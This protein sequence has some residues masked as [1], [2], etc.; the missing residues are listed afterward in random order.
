MRKH[1]V[2]SFNDGLSLEMQAVGAPIHV[3]AILPG[4]VKTRVFIDS[5]VGGDK[6]FRITTHP[7]IAGLSGQGT[8]GLHHRDEGGGSAGWQEE[9]AAPGEGLGR[10]RIWRW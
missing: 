3:A 4:P 6:D 1:A 10:A 9:D 7:E 2:L 5:Q 8:H